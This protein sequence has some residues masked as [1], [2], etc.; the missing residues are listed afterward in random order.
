MAQFV[1]E[2]CIRNRDGKVR[3]SEIYREFKLWAE[4]NGLRYAI[5]NK[6]FR[7]RLN[8]LGFGKRRDRDGSWVLGLSVSWNPL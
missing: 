4:Q 1:D 2:R 5:T 8:R 6:G 7:D 3:S